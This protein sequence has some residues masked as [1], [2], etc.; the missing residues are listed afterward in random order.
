MAVLL[1]DLCHGIT[2]ALAALDQRG[3]VCHAGG[4][5]GVA[6]HHGEGAVLR[7]AHC[8][9]LE[10]VAT[11]G[12]GRCAVAVLDVGL[13]VH[14]GSTPGALLLLLRL[15]AQQL[16]PLNDCINVRLE[17]GARVERDDGG[18][19]LLRA[20]AV[21]VASMGHSASY[22][23]VVLHESV[24]KAGNACHKKLTRRVS[25]ARV[26]EVVTIVRTNG[27]VV[28]LP[29]AVDARKRLLVEEDNQAKL[30]GLLCADLHEEHIVVR[31]EGRL[32]VNGRHLVLRRGHFVVDHGHGHAQL[33]HLRLNPE[34]QLRDGVGHRG[35]VVEVRLLAS[36]GQRADQC[37]AAIDQI[38]PVLV[39]L[40]LD[41][42][43]LLFPTEEA[44]DRLGVSG[45]LDVLEQAQA[46]LVHSVVGAQQWGLVIKASTQMRDEAAGDLEHFVHHEA[47]RRAIP[48]GE[49][50]SR[51]RCTEPSVGEG[52]AI[53][54]PK[55]EALVGKQR[56]EGLGAFS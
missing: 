9:E 50:G 25:L 51:V 12:K 6:D 31:G 27:P 21:I 11:E 33:Q 26:E 17:P 29:R 4:H 24:R 3:Q 43:E 5:D 49:G 28:V 48:G 52:G 22:E 34:E 41:D 47:R 19:S 1:V 18:R 38:G 42:K 10:A 32:A 55:E 23:L 46:F 8:A 56:L 45:N 16:T 14:R 7:G 35:K 15:V 54:L 40:G 30:L 39:V 37:A 13:H 44:K 20:Q 53:G 36:R 2:E